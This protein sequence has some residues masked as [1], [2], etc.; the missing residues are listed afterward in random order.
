MDTSRA[1]IVGLGNPGKKYEHTRH[2]AG[3][4][5][6]ESLLVH[7]GLELK[8]DLKGLAG[9]AKT[10]WEALDSLE[11][12]KDQK[13]QLFLLRPQSYMNLSA[14]S[15]SKALQ[16]Y[17]IKPQETLIL[18]DET[19]LAFGEIRFKQGGGHGGH[20]GLRDI[21]GLIGRDFARMRFGVGRPEE[22]TKLAH[23]VLSDFSKKEQEDFPSLLTKAR[24][25]ALA[26]LGGSLK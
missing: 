11:K 14:S 10:F 26:W 17:Q 22:K 15:V 1:L 9:V 16:K 8:K 19:E 5:I 3:A 12:G 6:L 4:M 24:E 18:H 7:F 20:N 25:I 2:N 23:Y 21:I 13:I